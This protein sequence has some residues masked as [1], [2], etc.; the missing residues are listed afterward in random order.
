[1][2]LCR[3]CNNVKPD[4]EMFWSGNHFIQDF[5]LNCYEKDACEEKQRCIACFEIREL[6]EFAFR[7]DNQKYRNECKECKKEE[8]KEWGKENR[9]Y[10]R[11]YIRARNKNNPGLFT[12]Q[13]HNRKIKNP[14][15]YLLVKARY[16][17]KICGVPFSLI[18][19]DLTY[20]EF[21]PALG[22]KL[23]H[24][25]GRVGDTSPTLDRMIPKLGYVKGNVF[26]L[27]H[28][29]N[30]LKTDATPD[31]IRKIVNYLNGPY[32][33]L[34]QFTPSELLNTDYPFRM[35]KWIR[36]RSKCRNIDFGLEL[37]DI[38]I[39]KFCPILGIELR[40]GTQHSHEYS[41]SIDR[42]DSQK[43]Y[44]KDNIRIISHRANAIKRDGTLEEFLKVE[45]YIKTNLQN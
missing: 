16:N 44:T 12:R 31:E 33:Q 37:S 14:I 2:L 10:T 18:E 45:N 22:I 20:P 23:E 3:I 7:K 6:G 30:T 1:M 42:I 36:V 4:D 32:S 13:K 43:G 9:Q 15:K 35:L 19:S 17:A 11:E 40:K 8:C 24:G 27:S 5:C 39:P 41:P 34:N 28:R 29:A 21:C 38:Q 25:F 26:I